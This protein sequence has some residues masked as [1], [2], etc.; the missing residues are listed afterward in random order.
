[1]HRNRLYRILLLAC[2]AGYAWLFFC[3]RNGPGAGP[4][5]C[6]FK[7]ITG[8]PCPSCGTTRSVMLLT[9]GNFRE[10][11]LQNPFGFLIATILI[12]V[13]VWVFADLLLKKSSLHHWYQKSEVLLRKPVFAIPLSAI[14][15]FNWIWNISKGI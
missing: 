4:T 3:I 14:V 7:R 2:S 5:L 8:V 11:F 10:S 6:L 9:E 1:M 15:I 12:V 13:P